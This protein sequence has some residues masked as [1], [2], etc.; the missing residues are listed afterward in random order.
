[1]L[2]FPFLKS[3]ALFKKPCCLGSIDLKVMSA[4]NHEWC[5]SFYAL[6]FS[7]REKVSCLHFKHA[8]HVLRSVPI[9]LVCGKDEANNVIVF[10]LQMLAY[11]CIPSPG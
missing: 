10:V 8:S 1:M 5:V 7:A 2:K 3:L 6:T 4:L 9:S 11:C